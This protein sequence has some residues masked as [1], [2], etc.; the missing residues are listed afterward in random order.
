MANPRPIAFSARAISHPVAAKILSR[1]GF[2]ILLATALAFL[3]RAIEDGR[4]PASAMSLIIVAAYAVLAVTER[5]MPYR[6]TWLHSKGD[7]RADIGW[8]FTN[9]VLNRVLEPLLLGLAV[10]IGAKLAH[11]IGLGLWPTDWPWLAQLALGLVVAEFFEYGFHRLMHETD[12]LWRFHAMHHSAPRLY[13]LNAVRFHVVDYVLVGIVK[14]IPL[15]I[16]GATIEVFA[17]ANLTAAIHGAY[18]HANVPVRL[19]A[20]NWVFSMTELHRWHHS[21]KLEEANSNYGGTLILWDVV[22]GTRFLP[23]DREP[24]ED[25]GIES[26][27]NYPTEFLAQLLAP[28]RWRQTVLESGQAN[29][30]ND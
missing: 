18:Q 3:I 20:L 19:G 30:R 28:F 17:L 11:T 12:A 22:F 10:V 16:L 13:W 14:L 8:F 27:P 23:A 29:T 9:S 5:V 6:E 21:P 7:L 2:P 15:A 24:P 26:L 25:I 4:E 1:M